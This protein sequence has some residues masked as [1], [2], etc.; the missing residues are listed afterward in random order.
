MKLTRRRFTAL[1]VGLVGAGGLGVAG[2]RLA[3]SGSS[4]VKR[5]A[6][7]FFRDLSSVERVGK[8]YLARHPVEN[9]E[10]ALME[11]ILGTGLET[12]FW[13]SGAEIRR[14]LQEQIRR[15]FAENRTM[16]LHGWILSETEVRICALLACAS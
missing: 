13:T 12:G 11:K 9:N 3:E 2:V 15:D 7:G 4:R 14:Q 16:D 1:L 8:E 6:R 10:Q 5:G